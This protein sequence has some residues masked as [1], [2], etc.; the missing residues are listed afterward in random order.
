MLC[1]LDQSFCAN[2]EECATKDCYRRLS[3]SENLRAM[4]LG[5]PIAWMSFKDTCTKYEA[6]K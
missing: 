5:L 3:E 6:L 4:S 2:Q 1:Y